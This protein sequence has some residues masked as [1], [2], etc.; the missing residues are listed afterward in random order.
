M[1]GFSRGRGRG[2]G[3]RGGPPGR[4]RGR[5]RGRSPGDANGFPIPHA[6]NYAG[7]ASMPDGAGADA[8][9]QQQGDWAADT[10]QW[11]APG[12]TSR[13]QS[14]AG[15]GAKNSNDRC[16]H[17]LYMP[18]F[19]NCTVSIRSSSTRPERTSVGAYAYS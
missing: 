8:R 3:G 19:S 2:R 9:P 15:A 6:A 17:H 4:G 1:Q 12:Q 18:L 11:P 7:A 13:N 10:E 5:G 16:G 14:A